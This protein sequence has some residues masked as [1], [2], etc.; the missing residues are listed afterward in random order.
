MNP[1]PLGDAKVEALESGTRNHCARVLRP[2]R[3]PG[4]DL[5]GG[6]TRD[7]APERF[8]D[9]RYYNYQSRDSCRAQER[10]ITV[11]ILK[12][13]GVILTRT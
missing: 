7:P 1:G 4:G 11:N 2:C 3:A 8:R 9:F 13:Y 5:K 12:N 10:A 6:I